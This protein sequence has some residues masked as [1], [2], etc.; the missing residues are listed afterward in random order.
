MTTKLN[1]PHL[2]RHMRSN[3]NM[4]KAAAKRLGTA[5]P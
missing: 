4:I 3:I 2:Q 5:H 1:V